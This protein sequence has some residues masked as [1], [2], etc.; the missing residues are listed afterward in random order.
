MK[1][2]FLIL[3]VCSLVSYSAVVAAPPPPIQRQFQAAEVRAT[4]YSVDRLSISLKRALAKVFEQ[5]TLSLASPGERWSGDTPIINKGETF[6]P[7]RRMIFAFE[8][9]NLAV[10]YLEYGPPAVHTSVLVFEKARGRSPSF[11]WGGGDARIRHHARTPKELI[12][13]ALANELD[14]RP[15]NMW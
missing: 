14:D 7:D 8:I 6:P 2:K 3:L 5:R 15:D 4:I 10:V 12:E 11:I 9:G 1:A 13:R